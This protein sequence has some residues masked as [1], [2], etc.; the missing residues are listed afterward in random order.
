VAHQV[1]EREIAN[2]TAAVDSRNAGVSTEARRS[3]CET[4]QL[5]FTLSEWRASFLR[6]AVVAYA[7]SML[8]SGMGA[9]R[10]MANLESSRKFWQKKAAENPYW[11]VSSYGSYH[12]RDMAEFWASGASIWLDIKAR[13]GYKP[14]RSDLVVEIGCGVGRL[15]R[16][17]SSEVG[18]LEAFDI[19]QQMIEI[20]RQGELPNV[21][22][23]L[24][25]GDN[26]QPL[27]DRSADLVLAYCV[28][29][30][31]PSLDIL[32]NYVREMARVAKPGSVCAFTLVPRTWRDDFRPLMK[33]KGRI[34]DIFS[35]GPKGLSA[36]EWIGIRPTP[37]Q[38]RTLSRHPMQTA[39]MG[40]ERL[41]FW[42]TR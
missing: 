8:D 1:S 10:L 14:K 24:S 37:E 5:A 17:I 16:V 31:L 19:S 38:V 13:I 33:L 2:R 6:A 23:H 34:R 30:H 32:G 39:S 42:F 27:N 3:R 36:D 12:E 26:L 15:S 4:L 7:A 21:T 22:F 40:N 28:F 20:A 18:R 25:N 35:N 9:Q 41:L 11:Y 29:Q